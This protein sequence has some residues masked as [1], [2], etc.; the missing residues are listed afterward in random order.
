MD[1]SDLKRALSNGFIATLLALM[2]VPAE[3]R[4]QAEC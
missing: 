3:H 1:L 2:A 4:R